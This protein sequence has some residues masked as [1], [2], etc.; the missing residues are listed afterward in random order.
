MA[1]GRIYL[2]GVGPGD[3]ELVTR[4]AERILREADDSL[5]IIPACHHPERL[6]QLIEQHPRVAPVQGRQ[7]LS[8]DR[9]ALRAARMDR[10]SGLCR[11]RGDARR[12]SGPRFESHRPRNHLLLL[13]D[14]AG[15]APS[16]GKGLPAFPGYAVPFRLTAFVPSVYLPPYAVPNFV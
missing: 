12:A 11:T 3:P 2:V 15:H 4:K 7:C 5:A 1:L 14:P 9:R 16:A 10:W 13:D 8:G 6:E